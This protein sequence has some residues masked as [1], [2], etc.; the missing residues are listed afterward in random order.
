MRKQSRNL[1]YCMFRKFSNVIVNIINKCLF[2]FFCHEE[3]YSSEIIQQTV[4]HLLIRTSI[5]ALATNRST[6]FSIQ[7]RR[8]CR[9]NADHNM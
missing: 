9:C 1:R 4:Q 6:A 3:V 5:E 2:F 7:V 8:F